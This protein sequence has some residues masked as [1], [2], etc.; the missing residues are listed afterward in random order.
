MLAGLWS[1]SISLRE[2]GDGSVGPRHTTTMRRPEAPLEQ[3][4]CCHSAIVSLLYALPLAPLFHSDQPIRHT[5]RN[6]RPRTILKTGPGS[7]VGPRSQVEKMD[8]EA[9]DSDGPEKQWPISL[10]PF[11]IGGTEWPC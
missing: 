10:L 7:R 5:T 3:P 9:L 4:A 6:V 11:L 8:E 2:H 1:R